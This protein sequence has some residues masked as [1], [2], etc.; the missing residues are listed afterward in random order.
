MA[1]LTFEVLLERRGGEWVATDVA[2]N[3]RVDGR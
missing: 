1:G 3:G 2:D